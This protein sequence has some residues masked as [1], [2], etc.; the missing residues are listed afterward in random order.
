MPSVIYKGKAHPYRENQSPTL[1]DAAS[2]G[3][4]VRVRCTLCKIT[5][6]FR[7]IDIERLLQ[8]NLHVLNLQRKF[9]ATGAVAETT[10]SLSS[11]RW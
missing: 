4:F 11:G 9:S 8:E 5:R 7:P 2:K 10:W 1:E 6:Y 3:Q